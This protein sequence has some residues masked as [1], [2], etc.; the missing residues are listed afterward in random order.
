LKL[1]L[2]ASVVVASERM[3][4]PGHVRSRAAVNRVLRGSDEIVVPAI[5][6]VEVV[7][8]LARR[9]HDAIAAERL[10]DAILSPPAEVVTLGPRRAARIA[11]YAASFGLRAADAC[12][13]WVASH[14]GLPLVTLD[15]EVVRRVPAGVARLP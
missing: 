12:Y 8:A 11:R 2:D 13:A 9:G 7:A 5:F 15:D 1:V 6:H 3:A 10:V 4:E 14:R